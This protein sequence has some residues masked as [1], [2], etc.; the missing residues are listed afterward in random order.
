MHSLLTILLIS[1]VILAFIAWIASRPRGAQLKSFA[2]VAEGTYENGKTF[3]ADAAFAE[4]HLIGKLGAAIGGIDVCGVGD[5][6]FGV[7]DEAAASADY[8]N[9]QFLGKGPSKIARAVGTVTFKERLVP[10]AAGR[11]RTL[12]TDPGTYWV[13]GVALSTQATTGQLVEFA[14]CAPQQVVVES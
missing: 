10:A 4:T 5:V 8:T 3:L 14:D 13:I 9:V 7:V 6:P 1:V 12:P 2:N 11:V